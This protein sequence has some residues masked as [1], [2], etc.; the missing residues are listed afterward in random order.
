M[1][2]LLVSSALPAAETIPLR[3]EM[4]QDH[5]AAESRSLAMR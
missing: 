5:A 3:L 2:Y 1:L 4:L